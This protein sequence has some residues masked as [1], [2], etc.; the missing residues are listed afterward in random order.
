MSELADIGNTVLEHAGVKFRSGRFPYGSGERPHQHDPNDRYSIQY[1][2]DDGKRVIGT[3]T[4]Y[5]VVNR[6]LKTF[7][8]GLDTIESGM[9][10]VSREVSNTP[11]PR[12]DYRPEARS[13][14]DDELRA[15][16]NRMSM[17]KQYSQMMNEMNPQ[18][19]SRSVETLSKVLKYGV[20]IIGGAKV[21]Y[22]F[23]SDIVAQRAA[24]QEKAKTKADIDRIVEMFQ[25]DP[26]YAFVDG[27]SIDAMNKV[28]NKRAVWLKNYEKTKKY[29]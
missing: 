20:P 3:E 14:T 8:R 16:L 10:S 18:R 24:S 13:M 5:E 26:D 27:M 7:K 29:L 9:N 1:L 15:A 22:D 17:E 4:D 19:K 12:R 23:I 28:M 21:A 2:S 25:G 11:A 6:D